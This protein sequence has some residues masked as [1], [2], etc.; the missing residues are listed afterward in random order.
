[1][2]VGIDDMMM[3][4]EHCFVVFQREVESL[5][6]ADQILISCRWPTAIGKIDMAAVQL[7]E[8]RRVNHKFKAGRPI[9][10]VRLRPLQ[11]MLSNTGRKHV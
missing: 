2:H 1:M 4:A 6:M 10:G 7:A 8:D 5:H 11:H 9:G 3:S